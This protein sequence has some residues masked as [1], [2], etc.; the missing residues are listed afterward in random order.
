L[1]AVLGV[2]TLLFLLPILDTTL[3]TFTRILRGQSPTQGGRDHTSH[4]LIAFGLSERQAVLALYGVALISGI[5]GTLLESLDYTISLILIPVLLVSLTL[6]TAYL[7]RLKVVD[8]TTPSHP[9]GITRLMVSLTFRG[10]ILEIGLDLL[11]IS[12]AYYLAFWVHYGPDANIISLEIFIQSLPI[13]LAVTYISFFAAGIYR[14]LWQ[15]ILFR[16]LLRYGVTALGSVTVLA[17]TLLL[18]DPQ[19][20]YTLT[21]FALFGIFIFLGL[22]VSRSSFR[23]LDQ[24]YNQQ[25]RPPMDIAPVFICGADDAGVMILQ[26]LLQDKKLPYK[27]IG[28]LD[29]DPFKFG[30]QIHR[31]RVLGKLSELDSLLERYPVEGIIFSSIAQEHTISPAVRKTCQQHNIWLKG[32]QLDL[33]NLI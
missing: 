14:G 8:A 24:I 12:L 15:Y 19:A 20:G 31:V 9:G 16:D 33:K 7:G 3:V 26:W 4:R 21:V 30:R 18:L 1:L 27:V 13:A 25:T 28:F 10:R 23:I 17:I 5:A 22:T 11:I 2:P 6:L 29:D 32:V